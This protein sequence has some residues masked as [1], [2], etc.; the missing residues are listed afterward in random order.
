M[1]SGGA[2]V[3]ICIDGLLER[4]DGFEGRIDEEKNARI[5]AEQELEEK[6]LELSTLK[7]EIDQITG[8]LDEE[9]VRLT[10][11]LEALKEAHEGREAQEVKQILDPADQEATIHSSLLTVIGYELRGPLDAF[12]KTTRLL[13]HTLLDDTQ[14]EYLEDL[15]ATSSQ[16]MALTEDVLD[17]AKL[18]EGAFDLDIER[19]D[20]H[21]LLAETVESF[22]TSAIEN[23]LELLYLYDSKVP[24]YIQGD[25]WRIRQILVSLLSNAI[26]TSTD[27]EV[28]ILLSGIEVDN[29]TMMLVGEVEV[30]EA[31]KSKD[32]ILFQES[33]PRP[34]QETEKLYQAGSGLG[35]SLSK[36][37]LEHM[38]GALMIGNQVDIG[39]R[40]M[41]S[42][43]VGTA[44]QEEDFVSTTQPL[45]DKKVLLVIDNHKTRDVMEATLKKWNLQVYTKESVRDA[46]TYLKNKE[47]EC[48]IMILDAEEHLFDT[49]LIAKPVKQ[50]RPDLPMVLL[51]ARG[52]NENEANVT[53]FDSCLLKPV[54]PEHLRLVLVSIFSE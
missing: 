53:L 5:A 13:E 26:N 2:Y 48:D 12:N 38:D 34:N 19:L 23:H 32:E 40:F 54:N 30:T 44:K 41:F 46:F 45:D 4:I 43:T 1:H 8:A 31:R 16:L 24:K 50:I 15:Q 21:G 52:L 28:M 27:G 7:G 14:S 51:R 3:E 11:E 9:I 39:S 47:N 20:M 17:V 10:K 36:K 37:L 33:R 25:S 18:D 49:A 22:S 42:M 29:E 6:S 35:I